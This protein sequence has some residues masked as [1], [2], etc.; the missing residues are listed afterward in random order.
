MCSIK[1]EPAVMPDFQA[2]PLL[3]FSLKMIGRCNSATFSSNLLF[4]SIATFLIRLN[5]PFLTVDTVFFFV[6]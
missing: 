1:P 3:G 2:I 4:L 6:L 5:E